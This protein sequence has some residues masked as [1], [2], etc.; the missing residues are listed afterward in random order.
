M[1]R[2]DEKNRP[3]SHIDWRDEDT[4]R[5]GWN[6]GTRNGTRRNETDGETAEQ[7]DE[8]DG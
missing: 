8:R 6:G 5:T 1:R 3:A 2:A 4:M 7:D